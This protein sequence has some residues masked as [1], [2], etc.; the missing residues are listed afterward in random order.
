MEIVKKKDNQIVFKAEIGE[1]LINSIRRYINQ[2]NILAVDEVEISKNDSPLYDETIAH[3]VGL[4]PLKM[5]SKFNE[6]TKAIL[7]LKSKKE[8]YVYSEEMAGNAK[9]VYGKIPLTSLNKGQELIFTATAKL[10]KG[11]DHAKFSPGMVYY[12]DIAKINIDKDCP[13]EVI[14]N[15]PKKILKIKNE[16][17]VVEEPEKCDF[18]ESCVDFCKKQGKDSIRLDST[19]DLVVTIESFGQLDTKDVLNKSIETLKK[20]LLQASKKLK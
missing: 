3:R 8:G 19:K 6:K 2:I 1:S 9:I 10:G 13:K 17:V 14:N 12:R 18:C 11:V 16:K 5:E 4:I 20:D 7:K 15:C